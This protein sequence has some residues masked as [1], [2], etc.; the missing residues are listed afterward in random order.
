[1]LA[2]RRRPLAQE[3]RENMSV[4]RSPGGIRNAS[5]T[6]TH[7]QGLLRTEDAIP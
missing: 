1:M 3:A 4:Y 5:V 2:L 6:N 7:W